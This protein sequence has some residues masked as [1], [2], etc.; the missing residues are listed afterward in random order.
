MPQFSGGK[1]LRSRGKDFPAF[2][3]DLMADGLILAASSLMETHMLLKLDPLRQGLPTIKLKNPND[4]NTSGN[5]LKKLM[6]EQIELHT[7]RFSE[8]Y[9]GTKNQN[10]NSPNR[11]RYLESAK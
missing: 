9:R 7:T 2:D 4:E 8:G 6:S 5:M 3:I 10:P 1:L 11:L